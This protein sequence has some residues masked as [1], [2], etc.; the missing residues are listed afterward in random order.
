MALI[1]DP[2]ISRV[3]HEADVAIDAIRKALEEM[4]DNCKA[5]SKLPEGEFTTLR[6]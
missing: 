2:V 1:N 3:L 4:R 5:E 6:K